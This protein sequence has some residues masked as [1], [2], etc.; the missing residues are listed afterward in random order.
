LV[1]DLSIIGSAVATSAGSGS[2]FDKSGRFHHLFDPTTGRCA[3]RCLSATALA[4]T[5]MEADALATAL[6]VTPI[7][8][9]ESLM[10][11]FRGRQAIMV[12]ADGQIVEAGV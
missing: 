8:Q 2:K 3:S 7:Q 12:M 4:P 1:K 11:A 5:A 9:A 10:H 6:A